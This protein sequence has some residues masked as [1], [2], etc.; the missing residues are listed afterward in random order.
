MALALAAVLAGAPFARSD[1][2]K[3]PPRRVVSMN[4]CTDQLA[5]LLARPGQLVAIS[6]I[7]RDPV[8]S[9]MWREAETVPIHA[10][11]AEAV[12]GLAPDLVLAGAWDPPAT[13]ALLRRLGIRVETFPVERS[14]DDI[15]A[16]V[17]RMGDLLGNPDDARR[18]AEAMR[19][20]LAELAPPPE[21]EPRPRAALYYANG[22]TSGADTLADA[23]LA[24]AGYANVAAERGIAGLGSLPLELLVTERP[25]LLVL[26]Q[27]YPTPALAQGILRHPVLRALETR[28][29]SVADNLWVCGTPLALDA[30]ADLIAARP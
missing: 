25:E 28:R 4:L 29:A 2:P 8:S 9:A 30:V 6:P 13:L 18:L 20:R 19:T 21:P 5:M 11:S 16:N 12:L 24:A 14:F 22:Y 17:L 10:D 27:D 23:I 1:D 3:P 15:E 7:A 26:G